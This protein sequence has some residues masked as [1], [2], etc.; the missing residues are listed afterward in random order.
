MPDSSSTYLD[1]YRPSHSKIKCPKCFGV[2]SR[3]MDGAYWAFLTCSRCQGRGWLTV[4]NIYLKD[5]YEPQ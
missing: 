2:P 1:S 5:S 4:E 3:Y